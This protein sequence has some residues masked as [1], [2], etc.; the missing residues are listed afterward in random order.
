MTDADAIRRAAS[1]LRASALAVALLPASAPAD[2]AIVPASADN[3]LIESPTGALSNGAGPAFFV[4]RTSQS[5]NYRRRGLIRFDVAAALPV[6]AI[7]RQVELALVL[8]PSN[9]QPIEIGLDRVLVDWGEGESSA[10]GGSGA[11]A[12]P[13]DAT[14][15]HTFYDDAFWSTPGGD[16]IAEASAQREVGDAGEI[17]WES[18]PAAVSDVQAWLDD[19]GSNHGWLLLGDESAPTSSKRFAS[20][21]AEDSSTRPR[22]V[23][24]Y[25]LP[26]TALALE[27]AARA[28]CQVWCET[29][30]CDAPAPAV[31]PRACAQVARLFALRSGGASL[32][33]AP[34]ADR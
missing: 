10:S 12:A 25:Q 30:D 31:S 20:R 32:V 15:I 29:L 6:G 34:H 33:C 21:E 4:G 7:V 27:G 19:P 17:V 23:V 22:L 2:T 9:P 8:T 5:A 14:W 18:T 3:T 24:D 1:W 16:F 13:G 11:P 28:L 26:C